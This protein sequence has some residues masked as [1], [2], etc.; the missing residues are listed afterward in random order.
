MPL[1]VDQTDPML[2]DASIAAFR[3][4][5][6]IAAGLAFAGAV[7]AWAR[8]SNEEARARDDDRAAAQAIAEPGSTS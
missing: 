3:V 5:M 7:V 6:L 1:A 4:G 2:R 8:I